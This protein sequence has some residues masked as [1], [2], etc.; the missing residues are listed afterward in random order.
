MV[1]EQVLVLSRQHRYDEAIDSLKPIMDANPREPDYHAHHAWLL[2]Q[3]Y[4]KD[5]SLV[6]RMFG[7]VNAA[8]KLHPKHEKANLYKAQL[9]RRMGRKREANALFKRVSEIN[10]RSVDA[11]REVRIASMRQSGGARAKVEKATGGLFGKLFGK[12]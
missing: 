7:S 1:F 11:Q 3:K 5:N 12:G 9:M 4:P 10:P 2:M 6:D 8:L